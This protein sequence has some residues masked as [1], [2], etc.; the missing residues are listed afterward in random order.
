ML[1]ARV[2]GTVT[3][4]DDENVLVPAIEQAINAHGRIRFLYQ[5]GS[6]FESYAARA[7][8]DD[9][10]LG[11]SHLKAW[12]KLALVTDHEWLAGAARLFVFVMPCPI[13]VFAD[14]YYDSAVKWV[15]SED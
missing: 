5:L 4:S 7:M 15:A 11:F 10:K 9:M 1:G 12:K 3:A 2:S 8:W 6:G 13:N 14:R